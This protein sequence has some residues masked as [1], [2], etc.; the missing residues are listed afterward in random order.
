MIC[1]LTE[2]LRTYPENN[3]VIDNWVEAQ[4]VDCVTGNTQLIEDGV[5]ARQQIIYLMRPVH[6]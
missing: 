4:T 2:L 1:S 5:K 3:V 6:R